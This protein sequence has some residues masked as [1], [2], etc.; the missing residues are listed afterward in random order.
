MRLP[1]R[2]VQ[3]C[4]TYLC[5]PPFKA[6]YT[7]IM[8]KYL[9]V[10]LALV[11]S[12]S[13][14]AQDCSQA[15]A[16]Q[17]CADDAPPQDTLSPNPVNFGCMDMANV[18]FYSFHTNSVADQYSAEVTIT[19]IDCDNPLGPDLI[20]VMVVQ[21]L[22]NSDPCNAA[23]YQNPLCAQNDVAFTLQLNTL[24]PDQDYLILVGSDHDPNYGPCEFSIDLS[25]DA[26]DLV[27]TANPPFF[28]LGESSELNVAGQ[29]STIGV[30]WSNPE[31]LDSGTSTN[32]TAT[33]DES[34]VFI[35]TGQVD[36][37]VL[38]DI[39]TVELGPPIIIYNTFTPNGDGIN[40][41]WNLSGIQ[42]F[43]NC[44]VNIFDRWG[45]NLFKSTSYSKPWD[46]TYKGNYLP[47][48]AYYYTIELNSLE[49]TIP[50]LT[51]VV[52]IVH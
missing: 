8:S 13:L 2:A 20:Q 32:P 11:C 43:P 18:Y 46:G 24:A 36:G 4:G 52:S 25:G 42:R 1:L 39:V 34:M 28:T 31:F 6:A 10:L 33:P 41:V 16:N 30:N 26:V 50:P 44:Q 15:N 19:P 37:C 27:A 49:V 47:T 38:T 3:V 40:D 12:A 7:P 35:V 22:N 17:L 14:S 5:S 48:A 45:Q 29:D 51:G 9:L 21:V 23:F